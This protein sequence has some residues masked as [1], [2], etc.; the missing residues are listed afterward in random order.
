MQIYAIY[1]DKTN[2]W[3]KTCHQIGMRGCSCGFSF[4]VTQFRV[5]RMTCSYY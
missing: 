1:E 5:T 4:R 2:F 3:K